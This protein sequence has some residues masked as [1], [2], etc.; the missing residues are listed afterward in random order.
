[1]Q[2]VSIGGSGQK[3]HSWSSECFKFHKSFLVNITS[4]KNIAF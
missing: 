2:E 3:L 1:M 4:L